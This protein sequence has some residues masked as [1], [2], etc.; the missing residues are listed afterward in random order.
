MKQ[1]ASN[2]YSVSILYQR[3]MKSAIQKTQKTDNSQSFY[4]PATADPATKKKESSL[5]AVREPVKCLILTWSSKRILFL[6]DSFR[7]P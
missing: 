5:T 2:A 7:V 6:P 4:N 3:M 1:P